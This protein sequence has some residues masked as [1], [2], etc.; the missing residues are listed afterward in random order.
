MMLKKD[1]TLVF[2]G[3]LEIDRI[4]DKDQIGAKQLYKKNINYDLTAKT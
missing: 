1:K 2:N 4:V 3:S